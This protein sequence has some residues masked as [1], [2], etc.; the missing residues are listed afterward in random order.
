MENPQVNAEIL[1]NQLQ[2]SLCNL[3]IEN[4]HLK[5]MLEQ[6]NLEKE[7]LMKNQQAE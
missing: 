5:A 1:V 7:Q 3:T 6:S 2:T 4:A